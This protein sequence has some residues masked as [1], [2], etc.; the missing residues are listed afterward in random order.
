M[1][2]IIYNS[3]SYDAIK[4]LKLL[5][6]IVDIYLPDLKYAINEKARELSHIKEYPEFSRQAVIEM[7]RQVGRLSVNE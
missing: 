4:T 1:L 2:P 3:N 5:D 7:F 6:G